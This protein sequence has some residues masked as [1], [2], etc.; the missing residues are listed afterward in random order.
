MQREQ[1]NII[2]TGKSGVGKSSFLNY[3]S[4]KDFFQTG[5]GAP[6]TQQYF[7]CV[8]YEAD[9]G[10]LYRLF[11][12][13]GI[14]P[15]TASECRA[16]VIKRINE[17]D[18]QNNFFD[19]IHTVYYCF[20]ASG[21]RIEDFEVDFIKQMMEKASVIIL[22]TKKDLVDDDA[23]EQIKSQIRK[24][25]GDKVQVISVCSVTVKTR[26]GESSPSGR[27]SV[28]RAGFLG[29]WNKIAKTRCR[30]IASMI[31]SP[32]DWNAVERALPDDEVMRQMF[33]EIRRKHERLTIL[34]FLQHVNIDN[35]WDPFM[36]SMMLAQCRK[37]I[38]AFD[39]EHVCAT[40]QDIY[41]SIFTFYQKLNGF[42]PDT[43]YSHNSK[44]EL[45]KIK[46]YDID[47]KI[48]AIASIREEL[49]A[50]EK[51]V[52]GTFLFDGKEKEVLEHR[53]GQYRHR[54]KDTAKDISRM[55][56]NFTKVYQTELYQYG[57][58]CLRDDQLNTHS[59]EIASP[60][61]LSRNE[62]I[63]YRLYLALSRADRADDVTLQVIAE[64]LGISGS[65]SQ[66]IIN[67]AA[68]KS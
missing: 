63:F 17:C 44:E 67:F 53:R 27:E 24:E 35:L 4:G 54:V 18:R 62:T 58:D 43:I 26:K 65:D 25:I 23:I 47:S 19:W 20:A 33:P 14:E 13:K 68:A 52:D 12:T 51:D 34:Q 37:N 59:G 39:A 36:F 10:V 22:L 38:M 56:E 60:A 66:K 28:L 61:D 48:A 3:L 21:K 8:D 45:V 57:Q 16:E 2:I 32:I 11:D 46:H 29:L 30:K 64:T 1:L 9:N 41:N 15:D 7:E 49:T 6:V 50:A 40:N 42:F 5:I 31:D 55:L